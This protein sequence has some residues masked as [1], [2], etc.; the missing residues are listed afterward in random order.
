MR[1]LLDNDVDAGVLGVLM[2]AG[3]EAFTAAQV[4]LAGVDAAKDDFVSVAAQDTYQ[5]TVV[6]H[7]REFTLRR[8][9]NTFGRHVLLRCSQPDAVEVVADHIDEIVDKA[10][11]REDVVVEVSHEGAVL[12][13][14][15]WH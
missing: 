15:R 5:A 13:K 7:D 2:Q 14:P 11:S 1:F 9:R 10:S 12:H 6:T 8:K 3:H 4:G